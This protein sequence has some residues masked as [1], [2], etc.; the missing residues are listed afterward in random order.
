MPSMYSKRV[1]CETEGI[2]LADD[3]TSIELLQRIARRWASERFVP[4]RAELERQWCPELPAALI[5]DMAEQGWLTS[6]HDG[7]DDWSPL[8]MARLGQAL[9]EEAPAAF[10]SILTHVLALHMA[11]GISLHDSP[12]EVVS[13]VLATSPYWNF[14]RVAST[15]RIEYA[16]GGWVL[17]G[18][19]PLIING[20]AA[21]FILVPAQTPEG[22]QLI[23]GVTSKQPG[24]TLSKS[25][26]LLG[27]RGAAARNVQ[28][29][30]V[31]VTENSLVSRGELVDASLARAYF[32]SEW[33]VVGLLSGLIARAWEEASNYAS[34][35]MQG[36]KRIID[37]LPVSRLIE[38][39]RSEKDSLNVWLA[40]L[41]ANDTPLPAPLAKAC[42]SAIL[43]TDA[44]LQV[45]GGIGYV[46]PSVA[47][48][49]WRDA[50]QA[51]TLCS[52]KACPSFGL[53]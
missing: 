2:P 4:A 42:R 11:A 48:R 21:S 40:Q 45:L 8:S 13:P 6:R 46:C 34:L 24:V 53:V 44:A 9:G 31:T 1:Y 41:S 7:T 19:L 37:H 35:R 27:L 30:A 25:I 12:S 5:G 32:I 10:A 33:G 39:A 16:K 51:A 28:F 26:P 23:C 38:L 14:S 49:C 18:Y 52:V 43:A 36:G 20:N 15:A 22:N 50:R 47:E 3:S 29:T 17:N